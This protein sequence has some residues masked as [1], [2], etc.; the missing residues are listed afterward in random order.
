[1][2]MFGR[3]TKELQVL[4]RQDTAPWQD[5]GQQSLLPMGHLAHCALGPRMLRHLAEEVPGRSHRAPPT[6]ASDTSRPREILLR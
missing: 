6:E 2:P 5:L 4:E 1:M 3:V